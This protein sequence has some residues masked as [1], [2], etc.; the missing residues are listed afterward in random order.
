MKRLTAQQRRWFKK[1]AIHGRLQGRRSVQKYG[2]YHTSRG[3]Q[4]V[5]TK[6]H[7]KLPAKLCLNEDLAGALTFISN[8]RK[9]STR[10]RGQPSTPKAIKRG[11]PRQIRGY[12]DFTTLEKI[13]SG[14][15]LILAAEFDRIFKIGK[16]PPSAVD[17]DKWNP[18]VYNTLYQLGFFKAMGFT[19]EQVVNLKPN[20]NTPKTQFH[21]M[22]MVV[23]DALDT[24]VMVDPIRELLS[25]TEATD[26]VSVA[27]FGALFDA[28]ENVN[29]HAYPKGNLE[30]EKVPHSWWLSGSVSQ[31]NRQLTVS[32]YDQGITIPASLRLSGLFNEAFKAYE[33]LFKSDMW[34]DP[35]IDQRSLKWAFNTAETATGLN[36][37]GKGLP[38]IRNMVA[39]CPEGQLLVLSGK[40]KYLYI[41]G[42]ETFETTDLPLSGTYVEMSAVFPTTSVSN[43][44]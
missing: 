30:I 37:R 20:Y 16:V 43:D 41:N 15:A 22:P 27:L 8:L 19:Q 2:V 13:T 42:K 3:Q 25:K 32:L 24:D 21:I 38:N 17:L 31:G 40:G 5:I 6:T 14:A 26:D 9:G 36:H 12:W 1:K 34:D 39:E 4:R 18:E 35:K 7:R 11:S 29:Y 28:I 23:G 33:K 44:E 10:R